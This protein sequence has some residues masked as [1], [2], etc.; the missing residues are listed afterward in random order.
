MFMCPG[1][2]EAPEGQLTFNVYSPAIAESL[3]QQLSAAAEPP[4]GGNAPLLTLPLSERP[5]CKQHT[6]N[7]LNSVPFLVVILVFLNCI[8]K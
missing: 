3:K 5:L 1:D 6:Q 4:K 7:I 8:S 2:K